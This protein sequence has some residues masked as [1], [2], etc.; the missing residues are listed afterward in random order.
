[1]YKTGQKVFSLRGKVVLDFTANAKRAPMN[2]GP[3]G[4][5][6]RRDFLPL[7]SPA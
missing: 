7:G 6:A 1:M 5:E 4:I 2:Q 3:A